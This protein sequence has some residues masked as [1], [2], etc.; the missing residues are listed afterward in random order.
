[1]VIHHSAFH[2]HQTRWRP[3]GDFEVT[4]LRDHCFSGSNF[5]RAAALRLKHSVFD[6][7]EPVFFKLPVAGKNFPFLPVTLTILFYAVINRPWL[8]HC[9]AQIL[10][11]RLLLPV[12]PVG[13]RV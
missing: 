3:V 10:L 7:G 6:F 4:G 8:I 11:L 2:P 12:H 1:V 13:R 9:L 5:S